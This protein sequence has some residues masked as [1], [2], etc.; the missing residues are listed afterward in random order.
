MPSAL[1]LSAIEMVTSGSMI[2]TSPW[3]S[4]WW[5]SSNCW[6]TTA[7]MPAGLAPPITDR[8]LVPNTPL[9]TARCSSSSSPG[10]GF[11]SCTSSDASARPLSIL[12]M[13]TTPLVSHR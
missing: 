11:I 10:I 2:G 13:G 3:E 5:A 8:S 4:T 12:R 1:A 7:A 6:A 9:L